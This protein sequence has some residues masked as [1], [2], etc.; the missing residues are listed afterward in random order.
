MP[1][2]S[3]LGKRHPFPFLQRTS[4]VNGHIFRRRDLN[5]G[6][7][8][9]PDSIYQI[10][11]G[12]P[13]RLRI[14]P[15]SRELPP[16]PLLSNPSTDKLSL[17]PLRRL[18]LSTR[19][20][21]NVL[22]SFGAS[23][24]WSEAGTQKSR[25]ASSSSSP[26][27]VLGATDGTTPPKEGRSGSA[28]ST[29]ML[30]RRIACR[31]LSSS[32][33]ACSQSL[34]CSG[35][36]SGAAGKHDQW[37]CRSL[38]AGY[39]TLLNPSSSDLSVGSE[40]Q[41]PEGCSDSPAVLSR[42][43]CSS[44][45]TAVLVHLPSPSSSRTATLIDFVPIGHEAQRPGLLWLLLRLLPLIV[46][47]VVRTD[48]FSD[49]VVVVG[50]GNVRHVTL[51]RRDA[52]RLGKLPRVIDPLE[53]LLAGGGLEKGQE[54]PA[55]VS[56]TESRMRG[57]MTYLKTNPT[58]KACRNRPPHSIQFQYTSPPPLSLTLS[59]RSQHSRWVSLPC[60]DKKV[61]DEA[62]KR[63]TDTATRCR[64]QR[65]FGRW[66]PP[67]SRCGPSKS[68]VHYCF[69]L[70]DQCGAAPKAGLI[71]ESSSRLIRVTAGS[72]GDDGTWVPRVI[73][74]LFVEEGG[75]RKEAR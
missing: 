23:S 51:G 66:A 41:F 20:S 68:L 25:D 62:R 18:I 69:Y 44:A 49:V 13:H 46:V 19:S 17:S 61:L 27:W 10:R 24:G 14:R 70:L 59:I 57:C 34:R 75:G 33:T 72:V 22:N 53:L 15:V 55:P 7:L 39:L 1:L 31:L 8:T 2:L 32:G 28:L 45:V 6:I 54:K 38:S 43:S 26:S 5:T 67:C 4:P 12:D 47:V 21:M 11:N 52:G 56:Q 16:L 30:I 42:N 73:P 48:R 3:P 29:F 64:C 50:D 60:N 65:C 74:G 9:S 40:C 36:S 35:F 71:I 58:R 37:G 63:T